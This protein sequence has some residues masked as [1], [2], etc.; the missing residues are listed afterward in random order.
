MERDINDGILKNNPE[1]FELLKTND[2]SDT[3]NNFDSFDDQREE[4]ELNNSYDQSLRNNDDEDYLNP[5]RHDDRRRR[6]S[7]LPYPLNQQNEN[8][9]Y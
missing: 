9:K 5:R 3:W 6:N 7:S 1:T 8:N 2:E 4:D